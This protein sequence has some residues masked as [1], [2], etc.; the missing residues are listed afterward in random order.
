VYCCWALLRQWGSD[1]GVC[2]FADSR[3]GGEWNREGRGARRW[4]RY[5]LV[6]KG[7]EATA[8]ARL[9]R[10]L[11]LTVTWLFRGG[12]DERIARL[13]NELETLKRTAEAER[14]AKELAQVE[15]TAALHK[16]ISELEVQCGVLE[17]TL[18]E[19]ERAT[20]VHTTE[21][22]ESEI[23]ADRTA[24]R[25][26]PSVFPTLVQAALTLS[27]AMP[28]AGST[29]FEVGTTDAAIAAQLLEFADST[30]QRIDHSEAQLAK[31]HAALASFFATQHVEIA[32]EGDAFYSDVQS[33]L[34]LIS[35][36]LAKGERDARE[37]ESV[38]QQLK[39][40]K[41]REEKLQKSISA[42]Q[43]QL[44][45]V[46]ASKLKKDASVATRESEIM[47]EVER[48]DKVI[49]K[50]EASEDQLKHTLEQL[51]K[52][53]EDAHAEVCDVLGY[54]H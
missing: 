19:N 30:R 15:E 36:R 28:T 21:H 17:A 48:R 44:S 47:A 40:L 6:G 38:Q 27:K 45:G 37:I 39:T 51:G 1:T 33:K 54:W 18:R 32:G 53:L 12:K 24:P 52:E 46:Q 22:G 13:E 35:H 25:S 9:C 5:C 34:G 50:L 11:D 14:Q 10:E 43:T 8:Y 3:V 29:S 26:S 20:A 42:L 16:R 7:R 23:E 4:D 41:E 2:I 49:S 31:V